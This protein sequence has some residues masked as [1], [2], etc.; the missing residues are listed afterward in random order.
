VRAITNIARPQHEAPADPERRFKKHFQNSPNLPVRLGS[1]NL[2]ARTPG[3]CRLADVSD[4]YQ[5]QRL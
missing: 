5:C 3:S 1:R 2:L 4:L